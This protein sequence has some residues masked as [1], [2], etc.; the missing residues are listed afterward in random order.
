VVLH[1]AAAPGGAAG[2]GGP[3]AAPGAEAPARL[4]TG[5]APAGLAAWLD[6]ARRTLRGEPRAEGA[7]A[8]VALAATAALAG[9]TLA[10]LA[11]GALAA[12]AALWRRPSR[13]RPARRTAT[14]RS[15]PRGFADTESS[16]HFFHDPETLAHATRQL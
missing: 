7:S 6:A 10:L 5:A 15:P 11:L 1:Y 14:P 4:E 8:V 12:F 2:T 3:V 9:G 16:P 13:H